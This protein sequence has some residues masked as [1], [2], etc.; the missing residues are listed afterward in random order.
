[1][2]I[3]LICA[4]MNLK[5]RNVTNKRTINGLKDYYYFE[6][7]FKIE[8]KQTFRIDLRR[9]C[10]RSEIHLYLKQRCISIL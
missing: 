6:N 9:V 7:S 8:N 1:M 2:D 5:N 4:D 10:Q 3:T